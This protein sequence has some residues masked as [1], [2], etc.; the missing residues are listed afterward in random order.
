MLIR[1]NADCNQGNK[2]GRTPLHVT[3]KSDIYV[4]FKSKFKSIVRALIDSG[5]DINNRDL[6]R[7][8]RLS[9]A[10]KHNRNDLADILLE[11]L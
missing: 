9:V 11:Q 3:A 7:E 2:G 10:Q 1:Y 5:A 4:F 6:S 8:C